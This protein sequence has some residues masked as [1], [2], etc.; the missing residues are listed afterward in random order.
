M[1]IQKRVGKRG[2]TYRV[3][4]RGHSQTVLRLE[5]ARNLEAKWRDDYRQALPII[6]TKDTVGEWLDAWIADHDAAPSTLRGYRT[7]IDKHLKPA[8]GDVMLRDFTAGVWRKYVKSQKGKLSSTTLLQ[9]YRVLHKALHDA[10]TAHPPRLMHNPLDEAE[11]PKKRN[12]ERSYFTVKQMAALLKATEG[13]VYHVPAML[14]ASL[15]LRVSE[16]LALRWSDIDLGEGT[17][18]V[19]HS[20]DYYRGAWELKDTKGREV[21]V[22]SL[23]AK[24]VAALKAHRAAQ[25]RQKMAHRDTW[26]G[27]DFVVTNEIGE[28]LHPKSFSGDFGEFCHGLGMK[29]TFHGLRHS[30]ATMLLAAGVPLKE[31]SARLRHSTVT[32]TGDIYGHVLP[33]S[34]RRIRDAVEKLGL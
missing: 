8:F 6:K 31:V 16:V 10:R 9:D 17:V 14:G 28:P 4:Y 30:Q 3:E 32:L 5:D 13:T 27:Y 11:A 24:T 23:T 1:A 22:L 19:R 33:E 34:E 25:K 15:G 2:I 21:A 29:A 26:V 18:T 7:I 20:L 12:V